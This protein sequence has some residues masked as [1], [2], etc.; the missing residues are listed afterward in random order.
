MYIYCSYGSQLS[1]FPQF[2]P[3]NLL[4]VHLGGYLLTQIP[5]IDG[6]RRSG[7]DDVLGFGRT[8]DEFD[9]ADSDFDY[10]VSA[11]RTEWM[12]Q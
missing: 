5:I 10:D 2:H 4:S 3:A 9:D 12:A 6:L 11:V 8:Y 1:T 7:D